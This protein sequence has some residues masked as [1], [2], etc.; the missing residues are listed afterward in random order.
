MVTKTRRAWDGI[1]GKSSGQMFQ[2][3]ARWDS[4]SLGG[5]K[6]GRCRGFWAGLEAGFAYWFKGPGKEDILVRVPDSKKQKALSVAM[7]KWIHEEDLRQLKRACEVTP[8]S[9]TCCLRDLGRTA[10]PHL[11]NGYNNPL[12]DN[13]RIRRTIMFE[14]QSTLPGTQWVQCMRRLETET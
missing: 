11:Q 9:V 10:F 1:Q 6:Q 4:E 14:A 8:V 3:E 5:N 13:V 2:P 7:R 12:K